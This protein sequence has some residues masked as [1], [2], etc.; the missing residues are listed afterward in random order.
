MRVICL[1]RRC[2]TEGSASLATPTPCSLRYTDICEVQIITLSLFREAEAEGGTPAKSREDGIQWQ[3]QKQCS[4][5]SESARKRSFCMSAVTILTCHELT[6]LDRPNF[7]VT[8]HRAR[9]LPPQFARF[10]V[11]LWFSKLDLRDYLYHVYNVRTLGIRS[12]VK[13]SRVI[14]HNP[15][16]SRPTPNRWH[17]PRAT[18]SMTV[19]LEQPFVWPE[20]IDD[21]SQWNK[22]EVDATEKDQRAQQEAMRPTGDAVVNK[23]RRE[24]MRE[25]AKA[26]LEGRERWRPARPGG[27]LGGAGNRW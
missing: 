26:L 24:S 14:S 25:Q 9:G 27:E 23:E 20:E 4:R 13:Q 8:L 2:S 15:E 5:H 22:S 16:A 17:R 6:H 7:S 1:A 19:E 18:K 3:P 10:T 12:Y 21:F 11:P